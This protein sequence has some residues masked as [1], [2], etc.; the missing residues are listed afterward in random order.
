[1][2]YQ[3]STVAR[4]ASAE[5]F[6]AQGPPVSTIRTIRWLVLV[7]ERLP[8][9]DLDPR[10][11]D[12]KSREGRTNGSTVPARGTCGAV[13]KN[14]APPL[15]ASPRYGSL[16]QVVPANRV[17]GGFQGMHVLVSLARRVVIAAHIAREMRPDAAGD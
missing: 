13:S 9:V 1:M 6:P 16:R 10:P 14:P 12:R 2:R 3:G 7:M 8:G 15:M 17:V 4:W 11:A 5:V